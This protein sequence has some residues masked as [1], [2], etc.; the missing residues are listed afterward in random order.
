MNFITVLC[1]HPK[2]VR[3]PE[4]EVSFIVYFVSRVAIAPQ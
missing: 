1:S 2:Q 4:K 3:T